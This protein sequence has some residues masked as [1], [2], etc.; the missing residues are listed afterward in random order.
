MTLVFASSNKN[1]IREIESLLGDKIK[2]LGLADIHCSEELPE[3]QNTI[4][5]N[6][7]QKANYVHTKYKVNC[8]A[9]D[10]GL[11]IE[12]LGGEP[13]VWSARYAGEAKD[14]NDNIEKVL[15]K[16]QGIKNRRANFKTI[17]ALIIDGKEIQFEGIVNGVI[18]ENKRGENG[19]GYDPIFQPE[20]Y[21]I[22]FSEMDL[23][24]KNKISHR[25]LAVNKLV[26]YLKSK[27]Y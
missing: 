16:M 23:A 15:I 10:T 9:D 18:L 12:A 26:A 6:A 14:A 8:F 4:E 21:T 17:I 2:L 19:F 27:R 24:L 20:N 7:S 25:A 11:E 13:G 22:S 1:K 3:T 5:K